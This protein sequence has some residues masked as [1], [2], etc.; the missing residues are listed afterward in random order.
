LAT[1]DIEYIVSNDIASD[2]YIYIVFAVVLDIKCFMRCYRGSTSISTPGDPDSI[3]NCYGVAGDLAV[4][5]GSGPTSIELPSGIQYISGS[6]I[7]DGEN[8]APTTSISGDSLFAVGE[9]VALGQVQSS[10]AQQISDLV[11]SSGL[12]IG[13]FPSLTHFSFASFQATYANLLVENNPALSSIDMSQFKTVYRNLNL[14]GDFSTLSLPVLA[15][16]GGGI[17][18]QSLSPSFQCPAGFFVYRPVRPF[19]PPPDRR[20]FHFS[21][22]EWVVHS[23][24]Y[25]A[26]A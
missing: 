21:I 20:I 18:V 14:T 5:P 2:V 3:S 25:F 16:V 9:A 26:V 15:F 1:I 13:N 22:P 24:V 17:N 4:T 19:T 11:N 23:D 7:F 6:L 12:T 10:N 8:N